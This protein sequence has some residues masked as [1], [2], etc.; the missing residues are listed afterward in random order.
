[1]SKY[2]DDQYNKVF[3][4]DEGRDLYHVIANRLVND[5]EYNDFL[6]FDPRNAF[7]V[8]LKDAGITASPETLNALVARLRR[9]IKEEEAVM[10][11]P[12]TQDYLERFEGKEGTNVI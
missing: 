4:D 5:R 6:L 11:R 3:T 7:D 2:L 8:A 12:A 1:M 10:L 9:F